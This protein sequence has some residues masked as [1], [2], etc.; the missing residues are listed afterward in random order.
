MSD[1]AIS[2]DDSRGR[3]GRSWRRPLLWLIVLGLVLGFAFQG[4]RGL[5][6]PDEGRYVGAALQMLDSGNFLAPGYSPSE[7]NF[8]KPPLTYWV[9]AASLQVFG[10]N[11]WAARAP[12]AFSLVLTMWV[13]YAMGKRLLPERPWLPGLVY[14]CTLFPF[15]TANIISTDVFLTLFEAL[16]VLGFVRSIVFDSER[17]RRQGVSLMWLGFGLAFLTKGPP[18]LLPL[19]A[20]LIHA[21]GREGWRG[22]GRLFTMA[23]IAAFLVV[24][25]TWYLLAAWRYPWL[26]HYFLH[27]EVYGRIFTAVHRRHP[28]LFGWAV[29]YLPVLVLG[30]L[31]WWPGLFR[32]MRS[33]ISR[34]N[35]RNWY[36]RQAIEPFLLLWF[37]VPFVVFC[38]SQSRL[39]LYVLP[40]FLPLSLLVA[41]Q[42]RDRINLQVPRQR[43]VLCLWVI[44][45]VAAKGAAA[46][47][48]H[49]AEDNRQAAREIAAMT[50]LQDVAAV[51]VIVNTD[52]MYAIEEQTPWGLRLYLNKPVYGVAWRSSDGAASL[53]SAIREQHQTLVIVDHAIDPATIQPALAS[54]Q[55]HSANQLG[56]WRGNALLRIQG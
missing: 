46:Y 52:A 51:I 43:V 25:F 4:T 3:L 15:F 29:V 20:I 8:S 19:L 6:S 33:G 9:I 32:A 16:A 21:A 2:E 27:Q 17:D 22:M 36:R 41:L 39:P 42:L 30:S 54:C 34:A 24:G 7:L 10:R 48:M 45:L 53:C 50:P 49:P 11:T 5:W 14:G 28:G 37:L 12:Y 56:S 47:A 44:A 35:W 26:L 18:G 40:L 38:L 13:L 31:P 55:A 23:G 1:S